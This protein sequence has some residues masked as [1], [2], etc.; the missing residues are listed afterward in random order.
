MYIIFYSAVDAQNL[1]T[2]QK[3]A[4]TFFRNSVPNLNGAQL[5]SGE[6]NGNR[7][8]YQYFSQNAPVTIT[9]VA[10][11]RDNEKNAFKL[12]QT[13]QTVSGPVQGGRLTSTTDV[14]GIENEAKAFEN[15]DW[16]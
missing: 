16:D 9:Q 8:T 14:F 1:N 7:Y 15:L 10:A 11:D 2:V 12:I 6:T 5:A 4:D 13:Y 3:A